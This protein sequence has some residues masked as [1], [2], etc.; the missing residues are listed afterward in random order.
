MLQT[1]V[2][3]AGI[4][5]PAAAAIAG[6]VSAALTAT[7]TTNADALALAAA[8]NNFGT[9]AA[10]SGAILNAG[11]QVGDAVEVYN[12]GAN[13]LLVYPMPAAAV[14]NGVVTTGG[15]SVAAQKTARFLR[16]S[17][18]LVSVVLGA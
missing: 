9:V 7:G 16:L 1:N 14:N 6:S 11:M 8:I 4:S 5:A 15:F 12:G 2:M 18:T 3:A 10:G 13:A 17:T